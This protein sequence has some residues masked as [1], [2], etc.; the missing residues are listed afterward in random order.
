MRYVTFVLIPDDGGLH[1]VD[2]ALARAESVTREAIH[3]I[4][5]LNDGTANTIY[6]LSGTPAA[7]EDVLDGR[8]DVLNYTVSEMRNAVH[9]YVQFDPNDAVEA[10]LEI[11]REYELF[12]DTPMTVTDRG[13][14]RVTAV[15]TEEKIRQAIPELPGSLRPK[16]EQTGDY[17][18]E[19]DRLFAVLTER[20]QDI[21]RT[22]VEEGYYAVPRE[23]THEDLASELECSKS[24]VGEHLRKIEATILTEITPH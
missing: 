24:N 23:A 9:A 5:L 21:L 3:D 18:P 12:V 8:H 11:P 20:Q 2:G 1:P 7:V 13:G 14:L 19:N 4:S 6:E 16:L 15:G 22:A 10:L 17:E